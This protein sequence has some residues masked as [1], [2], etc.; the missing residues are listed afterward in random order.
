LLI[1]S[2]ES[3]G[4]VMSECQDKMFVCADCKVEFTFTAAEQEK[5][6]ALVRDGKIKKYND[7][8]RCRPCREAKKQRHR[9][10]GS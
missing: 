6:H 7:P 1:Y 3:S 5:L 4:G 2:S 8:K 10:Q 9:S